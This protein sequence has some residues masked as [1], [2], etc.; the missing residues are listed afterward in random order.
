MKKEEETGELVYLIFAVTQE[1]KLYWTPEI[2]LDPFCVRNFDFFQGN[3][4]S[5]LVFF[6]TDN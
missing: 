6:F 3:S 1:K 5:K 4:L 2:N